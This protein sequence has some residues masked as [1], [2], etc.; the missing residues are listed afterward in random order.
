M[1]ADAVDALIAQ[2]REVRPDLTDELPAM[3]TIGRLGRLHQLARAQIESVLA[4]HGLSIG[5]FDVLAALR[6]AG[7]PYA[8]RPID[9]ARTLMLSPAGMTSRLDVLEQSGWIERRHDRND[10]RSILV[11]LTR[12]GLEL[13]DAAVTDHIANEQRI[14][15]PLTDRQRATL[16]TILRQLLSGLEA[17]EQ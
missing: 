17:R 8:L 14:L 6:R 1:A 10:R 16:D 15:E 5:E 12:R 7:E 2:W 9:L 3:A 4:Q 11:E 13:V